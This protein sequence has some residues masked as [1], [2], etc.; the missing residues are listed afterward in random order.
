MKLPLRHH[1]SDEFAESEFILRP[2]KDLLELESLYKIDSVMYSTQVCDVDCNIGFETFAKWWS[3][4]PQA[5]RLVTYRGEIVSAGGCF[6]ISQKMADDFCD[7]K[8]CESELDPL[9]GNFLAANKAA[10]WYMTGFF[11][12]ESFT[13]SRQGSLKSLVTCILSAGVSAW[14]TVD[15]VAFPCHIYSLGGSAN[16]RRLLRMFGFEQFVEAQRMPDGCD[17][18]LRSFEAASFAALAGE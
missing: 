7:G 6:A 11:I 17:L 5:F 13:K 12:L 16:G 15:H 14:L 3:I 4:Y 10:Y 18:F 8:I 9:S 2:V 1:C